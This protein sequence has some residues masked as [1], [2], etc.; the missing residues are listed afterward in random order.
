M[1]FN[2]VHSREWKDEFIRRFTGFCK[3]S[4]V[5]L[6]YSIAEKAGDLGVVITHVNSGK[7]YFFKFAYDEDVKNF[8]AKIK[9]KLVAAHYPR[10]VEEVF[11]DVVLSPEE[12]AN[13]VAKG[14]D[15]RSL[16][17]NEVRK[18]GDRLYRIDKVILYKNEAI[19]VLEQSSV[20]GDK[21]GGQERRQ[22]ASSLTLFLKKYRENKF[23][24]L[25]DASNFFWRNSALIS[26]LDKEKRDGR[27]EES[28]A[29][30]DAERKADDA[31][32]TRG[33]EEGRG[34]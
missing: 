16:S 1:L 21:L 7:K 11:E 10:V 8:I 34:D 33:E 22:M 26:Y 14:A 4:P 2:D 23:K 27:D 31:A 30:A 13:R 25:T 12:L 28:G 18:V 3:K 15:V 32:G 17:S 29:A 19:L 6:S 9:E 20:A 24:D 5:L